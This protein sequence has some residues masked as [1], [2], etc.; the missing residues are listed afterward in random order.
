[1]RKVF[2]VNKKDRSII[3]EML[4]DDLVGRQSI[5][6]REGEAY[7]L[8]ADEILI[9]FSGSEEAF[10]VIKKQWGGKIVLLS[11]KQEEDI[12]NQIDK[13]NDNAQEGMGFLFS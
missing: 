11:G 13:E 8:K 5:Y 12:L 6:E 4:S 3:N 1:M 9:V 10:S 7:K 2:V